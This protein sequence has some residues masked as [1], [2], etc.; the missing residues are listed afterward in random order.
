MSNHVECEIYDIPSLFDTSDVS[1]TYQ[2]LGEFLFELDTA[3]ITANIVRFLNEQNTNN[4]EV[5]NIYGH[6][7]GKFKRNH[8]TS[9]KILWINSEVI[10]FLMNIKS[11]NGHSEVSNNE[12]RS[13]NL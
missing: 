10:S 12:V 11:E 5:F 4:N 9:G 6:T 13:D 2:C 3:N 7:N 8:L 1:K